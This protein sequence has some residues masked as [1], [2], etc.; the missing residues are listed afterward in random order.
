M[1]NYIGKGKLI[2]FKEAIL[3]ASMTPH[4]IHGRKAK[5]LHGSAWDGSCMEMNVFNNLLLRLTICRRL[6]IVNGGKV[7]KGELTLLLFTPKE[8]SWVSGRPRD[9]I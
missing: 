2:I 4:F 3:N 5:E 9:K 7:S 1:I 8:H 6:R